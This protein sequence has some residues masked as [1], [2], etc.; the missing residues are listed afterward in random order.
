MFLFTFYNMLC[1]SMYVC[2]FCFTLVFAFSSMIINLFNI[3]VYGLCFTI[4]V[5]RLSRWISVMILYFNG[6]I[7][8]CWQERKERYVKPRIKSQSSSNCGRCSFERLCRRWHR[9]ENHGCLKANRWLYQ[10]TDGRYTLGQRW[11][12]NSII[13]IFSLFYKVVQK[14]SLLLIFCLTFDI[15]FYTPFFFYL[16]SIWR[17]LFILDCTCC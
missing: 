2:V 8:V 10:L 13:A 14:W 3:I 9:I 4:L 7:C 12:K 17:T 1:V 6:Y 15:T 5:C 11:F 16:F